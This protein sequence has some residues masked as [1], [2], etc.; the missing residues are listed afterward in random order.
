MQ[1]NSINPRVVERHRKCAQVQVDSSDIAW[2]W[3]TTAESCPFWALIPQG[4]V[5]ICSL[6]LNNNFIGR[7]GKSARKRYAFLGLWNWLP[8]LIYRVTI[9][10]VFHCRSIVVDTLLKYSCP[11]ACHCPYSPLQ[12]LQFLVLFCWSAGFTSGERTRRIC[13]GGSRFIV[14][15]C[16]SLLD[17]LN[18]GQRTW[19]CSCWW[20]VFQVPLFIT[21]WYNE[22]TSSEWQT[23]EYE[24]F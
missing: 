16:Y 2:E 13:A 9:I 21:T 23:R 10:M 12:E 17:Q 6:L 4:W 19:P 11:I 22:W 14:Y 15:R 5:L 24:L 20:R 18:V 1:G 3:T 8:R 7:R